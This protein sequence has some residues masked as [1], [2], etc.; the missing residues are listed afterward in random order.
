MKIKSKLIS[1]NN[2]KVSVGVDEAGRAAPTRRGEPR[3]SCIIGVD[4][5][6][7]GPLAGPVFVGA[8][9]IHAPKSEAELSSLISAIGGQAR[10]PASGGNSGTVLKLKD[11]KQLTAK[12]REEIF[13]ILTRKKDFKWAAA[14]VSEKIIDKINIQN[15][16]ELAMKK[17]VRKLLKKY[18]IAAAIL[19]VKLRNSSAKNC[20]V[21]VDGNRK[22]KNLN[23]PQKTIIKGDEKIPAISAASIIAKVSRDRFMLK[24][25]EKYPRYNFAKHK[26]YGTKEHYRA[27]KKFGPSPVHRRSFRLAPLEVRG[28]GRKI[29]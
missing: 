15:A 11:S 22:I 8:V 4:E 2:R 19:R 25:H 9:L 26:G 21:L 5:A 12:R 13:K 28:N 7:R 1:R 20:L 3:P 14:S 6:G 29:V 16:S 10:L 27:L 24:L 23:L 18:G 17:A